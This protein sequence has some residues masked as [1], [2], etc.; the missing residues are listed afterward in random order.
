VR[1]NKQMSL[2]VSRLLP[3]G[4]SV[5]VLACCMLKLESCKEEKERGKGKDERRLVTCLAG[6]GGLN[7]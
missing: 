1:L 4:K 7:P 6:I 5:H 2:D 3:C